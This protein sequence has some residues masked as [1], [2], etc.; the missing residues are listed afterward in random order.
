[1]DKEQISAI[2]RENGRIIKENEKLGRIIEEQ[3]RELDQQ[4]R[5]ILT[6]DSEKKNIE[7]TDVKMYGEMRELRNY[8]NDLKNEKERITNE[9]TYRE[10]SK[11]TD[12]RKLERLLQIVNEMETNQLTKEA[13]FKDKISELEFELNN[14]T[15]NNQRYAKDY[16]QAMVRFEKNINTI[17]RL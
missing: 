17:F 3:R 16:E 10:E 4:R 11:R 15:E 9:I 13:A 2:E 7:K 8:L 1:M 5:E 6:L 12:Q 14:V